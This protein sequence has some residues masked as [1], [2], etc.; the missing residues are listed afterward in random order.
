MWFILKEIRFVMC[1]CD[2]RYLN[3]D[4]NWWGVNVVVV[5]L[6]CKNKFRFDGVDFFNVIFLLDKLFLFVVWYGL[7]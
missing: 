6:S 1:I 3:M 5:I 4:L 2:M 7:K